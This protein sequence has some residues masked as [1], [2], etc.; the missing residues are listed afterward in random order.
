MNFIN[1]LFY[2][3][4]IYNIYYNNYIFNKLFYIKCIELNNKIIYIQ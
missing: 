1:N 3:N 4:L 2:Y